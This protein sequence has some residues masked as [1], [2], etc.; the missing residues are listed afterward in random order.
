MQGHATGSERFKDI[1]YVDLRAACDTYAQIRE[2]KVDKILHKFKNPFAG[3]WNARSNGT[4]VESINNEVDRAL[5]RVCQH[6]FETFAQI[7]VTRPFRA[8][9]VTGIKA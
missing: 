9:I 4:L 7:I 6:L 5:I 3:G 1:P 8:V 2:A